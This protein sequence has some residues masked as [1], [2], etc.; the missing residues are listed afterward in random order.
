MKKFIAII[1]AVLMIFGVNSEK[2][3]IEQ[4]YEVE[5]KIVE[6][7]EVKALDYEDYSQLYTLRNDVRKSDNNIVE[8]DQE[9]AWLLM[10]IAVHEEGDNGAEAQYMVMMVVINRLRS[11]D[12]PDSI[13]EIIFQTTNVNGKVYYQFLPK[14][15]L[16]KVEPNADSHVALA[17]VEQGIDT[18]Q[19]AIYYES[20]TNSNQSWHCKN[21]EFLY[22][23]YGQRYYK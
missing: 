3:K 18:S 9:D 6:T 23:A 4:E 19:G 5:T 8:L 12:F 11:D 20:S 7:E 15:K 2:P 14:S 16:D 22:E 13:S 21:R 17:M 1:L 10:Q